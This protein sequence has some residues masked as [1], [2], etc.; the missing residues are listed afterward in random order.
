M[1]PRDDLATHP[2]CVGLDP[3]RELARERIDRLHAEADT[4]RLA[5]ETRRGRLDLRALGSSPHVA[6]VARAR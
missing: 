2:P 5:R 1:R 3:L 4:E 6:V